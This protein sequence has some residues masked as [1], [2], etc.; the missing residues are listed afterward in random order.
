MTNLTK[1]MMLRAMFHEEDFEIEVL[2]GST[3]II[4]IWNVERE[5]IWQAA[6]GFETVNV[7]AG[8]GFGK[9]KHDAREAAEGILTYSQG[10]EQVEGQDNR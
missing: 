7:R 3:V 9:Y 6:L 10:Y 5:R 1:I 4:Y 8:Y 2:G